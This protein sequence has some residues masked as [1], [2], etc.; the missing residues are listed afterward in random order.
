MTIKLIDGKY[1][2]AMSGWYTNAG[3]YIITVNTNNVQKITFANLTWTYWWNDETNKYDFGDSSSGDYLEVTSEWGSEYTLI[4]NNQNR[5]STYLRE[6]GSIN[7]NFGADNL[8]ITRDLNGDILTLN[9]NNIAGCV[10]IILGVLISQ[11]VP[12]LKINK[13]K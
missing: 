13:V 6:T 3:T 10:F 1:N 9:I 4:D 8:N 12:E 11:I 7:W 2:L 5:G